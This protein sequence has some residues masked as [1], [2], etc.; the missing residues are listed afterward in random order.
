M[1]P[2]C[3]GQDGPFKLVTSRGESSFCLLN[4]SRLDANDGSSTA[5]PGI[6]IC[7]EM[8]IHLTQEDTMGGAHRQGC[9]TT[10]RGYLGQ[11]DRHVIR[12]FSVLMRLHS[13]KNVLKNQ[14]IKKWVGNCWQFYQ[15][16]S[17]S[18]LWLRK[19]SHSRKLP[20]R[21]AQNLRLREIAPQKFIERN[22]VRHFNLPLFPQRPFRRLGEKSHPLLRQR[23]GFKIAP[24][25]FRQPS[26]AAEKVFAAGAHPRPTSGRTGYGQDRPTLPAARPA[27]PHRVDPLR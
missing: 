8:P 24:M 18:Q 21:G 1:N 17:Q 3:A 27:P 2:P 15:P 19:S 16:P 11:P 13:E 10:L 25:L 22:V 12:I 7:K 14:F 6:L 9:I 5:I 23:P 20:I 4:Q 26:G